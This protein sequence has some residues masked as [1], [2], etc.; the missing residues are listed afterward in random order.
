MLSLTPFL[1]G[2]FACMI[3]PE[4]DKTQGDDTTEENNDGS[5]ATD[6][7][8]DADGDGVAGNADCDDTNPW[9]SVDCGRTCTGDFEIVLDADLSQV[10]GCSVIE[11]SLDIDGLSQSDLLALNHLESVT[12]SLLIMNNGNLE[13]TYGLEN[14]TNIGEDLLIS[15]ND[16]LIDVDGLSSLKYIGGTLSIS[17]C[18]A[19]TDISG[20][21]STHEVG[22]S[23]LLNNIAIADL[24]GFDQLQVLGASLYIS[25]C[26]EITSLI[27]ISTNLTSFG[28]NE[29]IG[30]YD[31]EG[32][33]IESFFYVYN[34]DRLC[35]DVVTQT[36][37][38]FESMGWEGKTNSW[39]NNGTCN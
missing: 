14:L 25:D 16:A 23:M 9:V 17:N 20:L 11:G 19:L 27:E 2:L 29:T 6:E 4:Q 8:T 12:G 32:Y 37:V 36:S 33:M 5:T 30:T 35:E 21:N 31:E 10:A 24:S 38:R 39:N 26:P 28:E 3:D 1:F 34:N 18:E 15:F 13:T 7:T 22:S